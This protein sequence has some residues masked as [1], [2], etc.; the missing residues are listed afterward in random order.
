MKGGVRAAVFDPFIVAVVTGPLLLLLASNDDF[1]FDPIGWLD[2]VQPARVLLAL[3]RTC[4][5]SGSRL[6][7]LAPAMDSARL[8][9]ARDLRRSHGVGYVLHTAVLIG[10]GTAMYLLLRDL[11]ERSTGGGRGRCRMVVLHV[12]VHGLGGW[13]YQIV[14]AGSYTTCSACGASCGRRKGAASPSRCSPARRWRRQFTPTPLSPCSR[15]SWRCCCTSRPSTQTPR[16]RALRI[17]GDALWIAAGALLATAVLSAV[18]VATGRAVGFLPTADRPR[19]L[20]EP[21]RPAGLAA[22]RVDIQRPAS[23]H[24]G[25]RAHRR[26]CLGGRTRLPA[27]RCRRRSDAR[28]RISGR[29]GLARLRSDGV[30]PV[31]EAADGPAVGLSP[32]RCPVTRSRRSARCWRRLNGGTA[33]RRTL[34]HTAGF[35]LVIV[36]ALALLLPGSDC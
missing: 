26:D 22:L 2:L 36:G 20:A 21:A 14:A 28:R 18:N 9:R 25:P 1:M 31:R 10:G 30:H 13:N 35:V 11:L 6:Q 7:E 24:S 33:D 17:V 12:R 15:P 23:G 34:L 19:H 3:P 32:S 4:R 8:R 27:V 5:P 29:A 16:A